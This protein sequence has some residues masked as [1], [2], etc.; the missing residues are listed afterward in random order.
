MSPWLLAEETDQAEEISHARGPETRD[1]KAG[2]SRKN[3]R[4]RNTCCCATSTSTSSRTSSINIGSSWCSKI[5][6][7]IWM[8]ACLRNRIGGNP[9]LGFSA[10]NRTKNATANSYWPTNPKCQVVAAM[11]LGPRAGRHAAAGRDGR[12][13]PRAAGNQRGGSHPALAGG[14]RTERQFHKPGLVRGT[15]LNFPDAAVKTPGAAKPTQRSYSRLHPGRSPGRRVAAA[16]KERREEFVSPG[17]ILVM[18]E[19][20][21]L[22]MHDEVAESQGMG[23]GDQGA[24]KAG[25]PAESDAQGRDTR[26]TGATSRDG[27]TYR[28]SRSRRIG[29]STAGRTARA[30]SHA[31]ARRRQLRDHA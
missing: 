28:T 21:N 12:S 19:S 4:R 27:G 2:Q 22:V 17:L 23:R 24:G 7:T 25:G 16:P 14:V 8:P 5:R 9:L 1:R 26:S 11:H 30:E 29:G 15:I 6:I 3:R 18:D 13:P 10:R 20:G 31:Q